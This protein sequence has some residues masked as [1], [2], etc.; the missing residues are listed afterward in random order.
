M[1]PI[2]LPIDITCSDSSSEEKQVTHWA[3]LVADDPRKDLQKAL[4][5]EHDC[6]NDHISS[7]P[8][9]SQRS[10][11]TVIC[12]LRNPIRFKFQVTL[13][14]TPFEWEQERTLVLRI[15]AKLVDEFDINCD[16]RYNTVYEKNLAELMEFN[17]QLLNGPQQARLPW[18]HP[19]KLPPSIEPRLPTRQ[20]S[21][22]VGEGTDK[23]GQTE[24]TVVTE[25]S[26]HAV[27]WGLN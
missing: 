22:H 12:D 10:G 13:L 25:S 18:R 7:W 21:L 15:E 2:T 17:S 20:H 8:C 27:Q 24:G 5:A 3:R 14:F 11:Y 6:S 19:Q 16:I 9:H 1:P 4:E 26:T 23:K